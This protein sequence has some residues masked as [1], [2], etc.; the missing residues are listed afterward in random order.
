MSAVTFDTLKLV[1]TLEQVRLPREQARAIVD[2]V[3]ESRETTLAEQSNIAQAVSERAAAEPDTKTARAIA[4]V[5]DEIAD[6][7]SDIIEIR[8]DIKLLKWMFGTLLTISVTAL[9]GV[10]S[11]VFKTFF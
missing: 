6:A 5:R 10:A 11:L 4:S 7:R 8:G 1:D 3:R 2:V 9:V